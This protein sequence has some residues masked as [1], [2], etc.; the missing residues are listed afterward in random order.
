MSILR[1]FKNLTENERLRMKF[2]F[3]EGIDKINSFDLKTGG[4][5]DLAELINDFVTGYKKEVEQD[6]ALAEALVKV[7]NEHCRDEFYT[8]Y[9]HNSRI[10]YEPM[11]SNVANLMIDEVSKNK[12]WPDSMDY[13]MLNKRLFASIDGKE[14]IDVVK[15]YV[16]AAPSPNSR[17]LSYAAF[18]NVNFGDEYRNKLFAQTMENVPYI[19]AYFTNATPEMEAFCSER[20]AKILS[21]ERDHDMIGTEL[22]YIQ[23]D[24]PN[25]ITAEN[26]KEILSGMNDKEI[27]NAI[28]IMATHTVWVNIDKEILAELIS[29]AEKTE[30]YQNATDPLNDTPTEEEQDLLDDVKSFQ[31]RLSY[32]NEKEERDLQKQ[33]KGKDEVEE[34]L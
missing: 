30:M 1:N 5:D 17:Y 3:E 25:V 14:Q 2:T 13:R 34:V 11:A 8:G 20:L 19:G 31:R 10:S 23:K 21:G 6:N 24:C 33:Q 16:D 27:C 28:D 4:R 12:N 32:I 15:A 29:A 7:V 9:I 18:S 26:I 22:S